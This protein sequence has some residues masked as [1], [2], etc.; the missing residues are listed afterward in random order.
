MTVRVA[1]RRGAYFD[2]IVL[3]LA[4]ARM[5]AVP[6]VEAAMAA[7]ATDV[8]LDVL[9]E[10]GLWSTELEAVD[11]S[12]LV[13]AARG[14]DPEA[15]IA[16]GEAALAERPATVAAAGARRPRTI[17][18]AAPGHNIA[19]VATP[20]EHAAWLCADALN[21]GLSVFCF[22]DNVSLEDEVMLKDLA[23]ERGLLMLGPD[24]GTA[25][26]DGVGFGFWNAVPRGRVGIVGASGTGIQELSCLLAALGE[27]VSQAIG[28]G[29]R[30]LTPEVGGRMAREAVRRLESDPGT[31][32][33]AVVGKAGSSVEVTSTRHLFTGGD[34]TELAERISGRRLP[35]APGVAAGFDSVDGIFAGG[36]LRDEAVAI[37]GGD[38]RFRAV[39]YG[40]DRFTRGRA[41]PMIDNTVRLEA[42]RR[43]TGLVYLDVVLGRGAH[44][45][46]AGELA[47]ALAGRR[48]VV[49]LVGTEG[50]PQD[51]AR[52]RAAFEAAGAAVFGS[53]AQAARAT[54]AAI[55]AATR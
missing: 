24:C 52:Q 6:G 21:S 35:A 29:G 26:L 14:D 10:S 5:S 25:I 28:V 19:V 53:N 9:R 16:V 37:W 30:D 51:L 15:A 40:D 23:L 43:S 31:D 3:M 1:L 54:L 48:A 39:D 17:R 44:P 18:T 20:G 7:M 8:N 46:P 12:V 33:I 13:L 36:T 42:I 32:V 38:R 2:S 45:D 27:G 4:S 22:S 55:Q 34:I 50:D 41:H 47:P 49:V 11:R